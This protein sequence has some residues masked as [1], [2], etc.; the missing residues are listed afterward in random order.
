[1]IEVVVWVGEG[2]E[3]L[4]T[5]REPN[6]VEGGAG[7]PFADLNDGRCIWIALDALRDA[8]VH[9]FRLVPEDGVQVLDVAEREGWR[10]QLPLALVLITLSKQDANTQYSS[11]TG[12]QSL[13]LHELIVALHQHLSDRFRVRHEDTWFVEEEAVVENTIIRHSIDPVSLRLA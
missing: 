9:F 10:K 2:V 11:K 4:S 3:V 13:R 1:L 8:L 5:S 12:P 7:C 6:N